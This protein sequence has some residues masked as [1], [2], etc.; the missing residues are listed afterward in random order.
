MTEITGVVV[1]QTVNIPTYTNI[2]DL[3]LDG[4]VSLA[5]F[6]PPEGFQSDHFT[7]FN[8]NRILMCF[9]G[10]QYGGGSIRFGDGSQAAVPLGWGIAAS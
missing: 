5:F 9:L 6:E 4:S 8:A 7:Q 10:G 2:N 1:N 3:P